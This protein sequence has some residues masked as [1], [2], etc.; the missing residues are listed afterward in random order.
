MVEEIPLEAILLALLVVAAILV[1]A[2]NL[3]LPAEYTHNQQR[4][5]DMRKKRLEKTLVDEPGSEGG[6]EL[7]L[8]EGEGGGR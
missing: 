7:P 3:R 6:E 8:P 2:R 1:A 4:L 5:S